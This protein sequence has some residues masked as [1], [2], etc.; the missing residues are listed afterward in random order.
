[1]A[2]VPE[3]GKGSS[4]ASSLADPAARPS[5]VEGPPL[6]TSASVSAEARDLTAERL[7]EVDKDAIGVGIALTIAAQTHAMRSVELLHARRGLSWLGFR[8][9]F[10]VWMLEPVAARDVA[11]LVQGSRQT[12]SN[13]LRTL[14]DQGLIDRVRDDEDHRM[15]VIRL[16]PEGHRIAEEALREQAAADEAWF[17]VLDPDEQ[18]T[19]ADLLERVRRRLAQAGRERTG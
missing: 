15:L 16:T 17:S 18:R 7:G 19:L 11:T 6:R 10:T 8:V 14:E 5:V 12:T 3:H 4:M 13:H 2:V 1:M 9:L